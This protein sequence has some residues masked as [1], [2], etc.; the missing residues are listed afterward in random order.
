MDDLHKR[1][2]A[3]EAHFALKEETKFLVNSK[4]CHIFGQ[5][6]GLEKMH[7]EGADAA[8]IEHQLVAENLRHGN[9]ESVLQL[10]T[11][12]LDELHIPYEPIE[13]KK[14]FMKAQDQAKAEFSKTLH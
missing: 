11:H 8:A 12:A 2:L 6:L 9:L 3:F 5:W 4:A 13:L 14:Q 1:G 7:L 10:A